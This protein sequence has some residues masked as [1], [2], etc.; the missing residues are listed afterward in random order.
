MP[1]STRPQSPRLG[2]AVLSGVRTDKL[3]LTRPCCRSRFGFLS[4]VS[5][6]QG[7]PP[8]SWLSYSRPGASTSPIGRCTRQVPERR[9]PPGTI[10]RSIEAPHASQGCM[11]RE[12]SRARFG[13]YPLVGFTPIQRPRP[14]A[15]A[16]TSSRTEGVSRSPPLPKHHGVE[17][18]DCS[19]SVLLRGPL[20]LTSL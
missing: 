5:Y 14:S 8:L 4:N 12:L 2:T 3:P 10:L 11:S 17:C 19:S 20:H 1:G 7:L 6:W 13:P 9:L 18:W 15:A 16:S